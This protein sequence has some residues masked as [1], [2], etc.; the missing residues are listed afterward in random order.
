MAIIYSTAPTYILM[1]IYIL[2]VICMRN[3][4]KMFLLTSLKGSDITWAQFSTICLACSFSLTLRGGLQPLSRLRIYS[5]HHFLLKFIQGACSWQNN[6]TKL[7]LHEQQLTGRSGYATTT[8]KY[9]RA[10]IL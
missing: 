7:A 2:R 6:I 9:G 10:F 8:P 4:L 3:Y 1:Y 5:H